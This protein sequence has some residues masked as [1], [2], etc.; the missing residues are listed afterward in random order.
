[1]KEIYLDNSAATPP[2]AQAVRAMVRARKEF[3]NPA[4]F[5]DAGRRAASVMQGAR[6]DIARFLNARPDEIVVCASGSEA[7]SLAL[8][9]MLAGKRGT[10]LVPDT[11]HLSVLEPLRRLAKNGVRTVS[12]PVDGQG[13]VSVQDVVSR[14]TPS[15]KVV[16]VMYANNEVGT[17]QPIARIGRAIAAW[18]RSHRSQFP[19]FHV[20]A[21]QA[22]TTLPMDVQTL[23]ADLLTFNGAKAYGPH[24]I[25]VLYVRRGVALA[26]LVTGGSQE[27]GRRAGTEDVAAMAG[28]AAA[29]KYIKPREAGRLR[30]LRDR[31]LR[32]I[33]REVP[34]ARLNGPAGEDRLAGNVHVS[35]P[36]CDSESLLLELDRVGIR[37]GSGSAC[38]AHSVEPSHVLTA[39]GTPGRF[40]EGALR[41]SLGRSTTRAQVDAV[42]RAMPRVVARVRERRARVRAA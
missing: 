29:L 33:L 26:P 18:R 30:G 12:L 3:A 5:N 31:L 7:N 38:T 1:M 40:L 32:G 23:G 27:G 21:C 28:L 11:E 19:V 39:I 20:D 22:T 6:A 4:S 37:A 13:R 8:T 35:V 14:L 2:A 25:A 9:G 17:I 16:S 10:A 24:G 42:I 34:D 15:V 41:F 36:G